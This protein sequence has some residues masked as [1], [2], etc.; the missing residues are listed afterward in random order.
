MERQTPLQLEYVEKVKAEI[1]SWTKT[2]G[3]KLHEVQTIVPFVLSDKSLEVWLFFENRELV[4]VYSEN[5]TVE[6]VKKKYC[7]LLE[8]IEYPKEY[9]NQV[10]FNIDSHQNV[11]ENFKGSYFYRLR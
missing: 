8:N 2:E 5:D 4:K 7:E 11:V 10:T 3:I 1:L 6:I 9:L